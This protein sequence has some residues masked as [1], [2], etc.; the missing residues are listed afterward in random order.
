MHTLNTMING[1][2]AVNSKV[3]MNRVQKQVV[4][5]NHRVVEFTG[6]DGQVVQVKMTED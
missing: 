5:P 2:R 6:K 3:K 4:D 1:A